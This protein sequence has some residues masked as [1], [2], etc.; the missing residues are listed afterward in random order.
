MTPEPMADWFPN[1]MRWVYSCPN[2][3]ASPF[4]GYMAIPFPRPPHLVLQLAF[5]PRKDKLSLSLQR[6]EIQS[7]FVFARP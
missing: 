4:S 6:H 5:L 7:E 1:F 2:S 3:L